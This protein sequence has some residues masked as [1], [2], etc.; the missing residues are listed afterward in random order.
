VSLTAQQ[1]LNNITRTA[2]EAL[3]GVLGGTQSLHTNSFDEALALPTEAAVRVALRTQQIIAHETGVANTIDPLGGSYFVEALTDAMEAAA[4]EYFARIDELGG[5]VQAVKQN[6]PQREI[7]DASYELQGE[8]DAGRRI[9]VGVNQ[10]TEGDDDDHPILR[11][12]PALERKQIGRLQAVKG[13][14]DPER[15]ELALA[16]LR[17]A[18][19]SQ[20]NLMPL[21]VDAARVHATEGEIVQALQDVWGAF[22]ET[23][24]F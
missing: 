13:R 5:M 23:P 22:T 20:S 4:Y 8:I 6:F 21:L 14:R 17:A 15:V 18:A 10:Y 9:V 11:I 24:V 16:D 12:D 19:G 3:A 7:A 2:I 1:P